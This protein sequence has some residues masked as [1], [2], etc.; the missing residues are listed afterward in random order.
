MVRWKIA[1]VTVMGILVITQPA[2]ATCDR[3]EERHTQCLEKAERTF[4]ACLEI[5]ELKRRGKRLTPRHRR[6]QSSCTSFLGKYERSSCRTK[7]CFYEKRCLRTQDVVERCQAHISRREAQRTADEEAQNNREEA[8]RLV[9]AMEACRKGA[10]CAA[11]GLCESDGI[12]CRALTDLSCSASRACKEYQRCRAHEGECIDDCRLTTACRTRGQCETSAN[13]CVSVLAKFA[14]VGPRGARLRLDGGDLGSLD[15]TLSSS[16]G[17]ELGTESSPWGR[18]LPAGPY[19]ATVELDGFEPL[20]ERLE[21]EPGSKTARVFT[22]RSKPT[23]KLSVRASGRDRCHIKV[24]ARLSKPP[25]AHK[26]GRQNE[27]SCD[28]VPCDVEGLLPG[29]YPL[30]V[31]AKGYRPWKTIVKIRD[32]ETTTLDFP[33]AASGPSVRIVTDP[34]GLTIRVGGEHYLSPLRI[35]GLEKGQVLTS[36]VLRSRTT[37]G[38]TVTLDVDWDSGEEELEL[39]P[40]EIPLP[41]RDGELKNDY[42][43]WNPSFPYRHRFVYA[44]PPAGFEASAIRFDGTGANEEDE[45]LSMFRLPMVIYA[46][47]ITLGRHFLLDLDLHWQFLVSSLSPAIEQGETST[48]F[49]D[50]GPGYSVALHGRLSRRG[51]LGQMPLTLRWSQGFAVVEAPFISSNA[52]EVRLAIPAR[53]DLM[54]SPVFQRQDLSIKGMSAEEYKDAVGTLS[55]DSPAPTVARSGGDASVMRVGLRLDWLAVGWGNRSSSDW[56]SA[57]QFR[58]A[59]YLMPAIGAGAD[60]SVDFEQALWGLE[61][62]TLFF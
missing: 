1:T 58:L 61:L 57:G 36:S 9:R 40:D 21:L 34:E 18:A 31:S 27:A 51:L 43:V 37:I 26:S 23:G 47:Q 2:E 42:F 35:V 8:A 54:V 46:A 4:D 38:Q 52:I 11:K 29:R 30:T 10:A 50:Q 59:T 12:G 49:Y 15:V 33:E 55:D 24:A 28:G 6:K 41:P 3:K 5:A 53:P 16:T 14:V 32:G 39:E 48:G 44:L 20:R 7:P 22:L 56:L 17:M 45:I 13:G 19:D 25:T 62:H 60:G